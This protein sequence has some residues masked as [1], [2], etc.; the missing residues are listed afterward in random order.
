MPYS[1][2]RGQ[3][4]NVLN[5][6]EKAC[7]YI[8]YIAYFYI[9]TVDV[10]WTRN[11]DTLCRVPCNFD[12]KIKYGTSNLYLNPIFHSRKENARSRCIYA[13]LTKRILEIVNFERKCSN[14]WRRQVKVMWLIEPTCHFHTFLWA[15]TVNESK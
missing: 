14:V 5:I 1:N 13:P 12:F 7:E 11:D 9:S 10:P 2:E 6:L 15:L 8:Q 3:H 4:K